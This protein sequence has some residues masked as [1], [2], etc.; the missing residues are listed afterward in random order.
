MEEQ[1]NL[2][3]E[4]PENEQI[5]TE[6]KPMTK[7]PW[8]VKL[9]PHIIIIS[10]LLNMYT[11]DFTVIGVFMIGLWIWY[12]IALQKNKVIAGPFVKGVLLVLLAL[13]IRDIYEAFSVLYQQIL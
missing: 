7:N 13:N 1:K 10:E 9:C 3:T 8:W 6:S 4:T 2:N 5:K 11:K 12:G